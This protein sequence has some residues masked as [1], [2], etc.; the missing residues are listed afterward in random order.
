MVCGCQFVHNG[1][2]TVDV[3]NG[4]DFRPGELWSTEEY[5]RPSRR[6]REGEFIRFN[7]DNVAILEMELGQPC[8]HLP[9]TQPP[10]IRKRSRFGKPWT[11]EVFEWMKVDVVNGLTDDICDK[12]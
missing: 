3:D 9:V 1:P 10:Y 4:A 8:G 2:H 5:L 7:P 6:S 11:R 12:E